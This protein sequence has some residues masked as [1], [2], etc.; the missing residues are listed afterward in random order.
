MNNSWPLTPRAQ[1]VLQYAAIEA[2]EHPIGI[3]DLLAG[4]VA[5]NRRHDLRG[6]SKLACEAL[7]QVGLL[8]NPD[9]EPGGSEST[10]AVAFMPVAEIR[11]AD[12]TKTLLAAADRVAVELGRNYVA[13][14][15][16][17]LA[18]LGSSER[19]DDVPPIGDPRC[20]EVYD[21]LQAGER[22]LGTRAG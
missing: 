22:A 19:R 3:R 7:R 2:T 20:K 5:L 4:F 12:S 18:L 8:Q 17:V 11:A 1:Q 10:P 9:A 16:I 13:P 14:E 15:H 21:A 6:G